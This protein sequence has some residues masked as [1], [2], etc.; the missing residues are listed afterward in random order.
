MIIKKTFHDNQIQ[1][2]YKLLIYDITIVLSSNINNIEFVCT[3]QNRHEKQTYNQK[4]YTY[5]SI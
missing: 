4:K 3:L 1:I 5:Y 2:T